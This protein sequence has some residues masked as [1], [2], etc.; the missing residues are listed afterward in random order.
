MAFRLDF[1][2]GQMRDSANRADYALSSELDLG[3]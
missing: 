2:A 1:A 3:H